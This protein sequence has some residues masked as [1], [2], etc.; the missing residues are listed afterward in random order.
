MLKKVLI[1]LGVFIVALV[2]G[3]IVGDLLTDIP[4]LGWMGYRP[5]IHLDTHSWNWFIADVTL[6]IKTKF[7][8]LQLIL[9]I[10]SIFVAPK[11]YNALTKKD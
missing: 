6:G 4:A 3:G 7:N 1:Y 5:P 9:V 8:I 10:V 2:V 11:V